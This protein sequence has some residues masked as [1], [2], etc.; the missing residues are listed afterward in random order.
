MEVKNDLSAP[1]FHI[2]QQLVAALVNPLFFGHLPGNPEEV[3]HEPQI[4]VF[5]IVDAANMPFGYQQ[6]MDRSRRLN[7]PEHHAILIF[8]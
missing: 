5:Q 8:V 3:S 2:E 7:V 6:Q 4:A 1:L